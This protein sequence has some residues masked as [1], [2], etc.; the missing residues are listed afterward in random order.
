VICLKDL[1]FLKL[2]YVLDIDHAINSNQLFVLHLI[3][4]EPKK[5]TL[6]MQEYYDLSLVGKDGK[7]SIL[8]L[9]IVKGKK[10][11]HIDYIEDLGK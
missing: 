5:R 4:Q 1:E 2:N 11:H 7:K 3:A 6:N 9:H 8:R 10:N